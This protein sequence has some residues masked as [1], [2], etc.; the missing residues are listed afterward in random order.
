[1]TVAITRTKAE[2][3]LSQTFETV[4]PRLPGGPTVAAAR[5]S[6][7][8][9]FAALGL[10][11]RRLEAWKYTDLRSALKEALPAA[12]ADERPLPTPAELDAAL[13]ALAGLDA[14]R[15]VFVDGVY[16]PELS[17]PAALA[18]LTFTPLAARLR[19]G[20]AELSK[21]L[22]ATGQ[23]EAVI[24]LNTAFMSDGAV[25]DVAP[26]HALGKPVLLVFLR[27]G[28]KARL[29]TTRNHVNVGADADVT[30][31]EAHLRLPAAAAGQSNTLSELRLGKNA[32]L[33]HIKVTLAGE[34]ESHVSTGL[35]TLGAGASYRAFQLTASTG[36]VRN[37]LGLTFDGQGGKADV[38][39]C[40]LGRGSEHIDSTLLIDHAV[41]GCE[42]RELFKGVL[43]DK[44]RGV[45]QGKV[46]V[47]P[48]AQKTDG[49]QMAQV[50]ML[51]EDAEFDSKPELEINADDVVCGHGSTS[52]EI[53]KDLLFY[54]R[55]RGIAAEEARALL[56]ESFIGE[57][58]DKVE[59]PVRPALM[60]MA[61]DRL[62]Q[63]T[64]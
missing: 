16:A 1:M 5:R 32:K 56:I 36:L 21:Q 55:T 33:S 27:T 34:G 13:E 51:S 6:A 17:Q 3:G 40:F 59:E 20:E 2:Q 4:A 10:P 37:G 63:L 26:G 52:A 42:S 43:A 7:I 54:F 11:H 19:N 22:L 62:A 31:I 38:S 49:K 39:G 53:D 12:V 47:R 30:L 48:Q 57:A 45:F 23:R 18:G 46:I 61:R 58:I 28:G 60:A 29:I 9:A 14:H 64:S 41:A 44:A 35:P 15:L 25:I 50:L 8:G 24:A